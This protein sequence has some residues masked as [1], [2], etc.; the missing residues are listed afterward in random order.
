MRGGLGVGGNWG[1]TVKQPPLP[2][3]QQ[4][5]QP[6][7]WLRY[8]PGVGPGVGCGRDFPV[9]KRAGNQQRRAGC[10][11]HPFPPTYP[12]PGPL[13]P[14]PLWGTPLSPAA[15]AASKPSGGNGDPG[16]CKD[17]LVCTQNGDGVTHS[18]CGPPPHPPDAPIEHSGIIFLTQPPLRCSPPAPILSPILG[19]FAAFSPFLQELRALERQSGPCRDGSKSAQEFGWKE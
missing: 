3:V 19:Q 17:L 15:P 8:G 6:G 5:N 16:D 1:S 4:V 7:P 12:P 9:E 2:S 13:H 18:C 11:P 10:P 14:Q